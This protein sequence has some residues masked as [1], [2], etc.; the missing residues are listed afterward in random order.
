[1]KILLNLMVTKSEKYSV[2]GTS[3]IMG[4]SI[5]NFLFRY[6]NTLPLLDSV[7]KKSLKMSNFVNITEVP[8]ISWEALK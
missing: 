6:L 1:M 3:G 4:F 5:Y 8:E 7:N 2:I